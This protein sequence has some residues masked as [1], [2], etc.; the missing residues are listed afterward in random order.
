MRTS[1]VCVCVLAW[2]LTSALS[3]DC[4]ADSE[5]MRNEGVGVRVLRLET[6]DEQTYKHAFMS[7]PTLTTVL[8]VP[9]SASHSAACATVSASPGSKLSRLSGS[10]TVSLGPVRELYC[11]ALSETRTG[12]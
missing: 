2:E 1:V 4:E 8:C 6:V 5:R 12:A 9:L 7:D 11:C 10:Y 3:E